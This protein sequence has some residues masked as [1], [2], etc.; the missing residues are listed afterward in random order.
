VIAEWTIEK[1]GQRLNIFLSWGS[2]AFG[3]ATTH[4]RRSEDKINF[5]ILI[6]IS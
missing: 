6:A 2:F 3:L 1:N 4:G 5:N